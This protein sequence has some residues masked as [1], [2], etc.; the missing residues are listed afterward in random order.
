MAQDIA[1]Q[2]GGESMDITTKVLGRWLVP[3][4][5]AG[6][7]PVYAQDKP[8]NYPQRPI[9][10][11]IGV[12]PGAGADMVARL[13]A[14]LF[15]ERW[16]QNAVVDPRPGGGGVV[17]SDTLAK[18]TPDATRSCSRGMGCCCRR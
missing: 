14:Q 10:I 17:A 12:A 3:V 4:L 16:G 2:R 6:S 11:I 5:L 1:M 13:T 8:A 7:A 9:R 18:S 15:T